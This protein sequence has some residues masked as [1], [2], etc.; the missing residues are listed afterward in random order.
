MAQDNQKGRPKRVGLSSVRLDVLEKALELACGD[1][2]R[3]QVLSREEVV[4]R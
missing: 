2:E 3:I 4:V 1:E